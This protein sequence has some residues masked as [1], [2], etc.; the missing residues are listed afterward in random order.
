MS[1]TA[2]SGAASYQVLQSSDGGTTW[3]NVTAGDG[4]QPM[5]NSTTVTGLTAG[6]SYEFEV[7]AV[8]ANSNASAPSPASTAVEYGMKAT[9]LAAHSG[10]QQVIITLNNGIGTAPISP[11]AIS[12][13]TVTDVTKSKTITATSISNNNGNRTITLIFA[14][15]TISTGDSI[16]L[17]ATH[18]TAVD[19]A[20][21]PLAPITTPLIVTVVA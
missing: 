12:D 6:V 11:G 16:T 2:S 14:N 4:G 15:G 13:Y 7:E 20:N 8:D 19:N 18:P 21:A 9:S 5:T 17:T 1:W 3:S 10:N